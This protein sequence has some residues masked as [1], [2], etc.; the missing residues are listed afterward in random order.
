MLHP[1]AV[2]AKGAEVHPDAAIGPYCVL[3]EHVRIGADTELVSHVVVS[4]HT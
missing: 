4:G 1:T 2:I 3:G